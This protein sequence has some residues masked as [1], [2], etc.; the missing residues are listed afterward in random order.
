M[1]ALVLFVILFQI[2]RAIG[3]TTLGHFN[4]DT[5]L[6]FGANIKA[7]I[8][9]F[10]FVLAGFLSMQSYKNKKYLKWVGIGLLSIFV[11]LVVSII[12]TK[13]ILNNNENTH[14][15]IQDPLVKSISMRLYKNIDYHAEIMKNREN[16]TVLLSFKVYKDGTAT[17]TKLEGN[18][19]YYESVKESMQKTFP[20][21]MPDNNTSF[22][23]E[24]KIKINFGLKR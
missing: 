9:I 8:E 13:I 20:I 19:K 7:S 17:I 3:I 22:P 6:E 1:M 5:S 14:S 15:Y 10:S 23:R 4:I 2:F 18:E 12:T 16:G 24:I 21:K 11:V